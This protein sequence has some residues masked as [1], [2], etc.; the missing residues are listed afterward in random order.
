[1]EYSRGTIS[2]EAIIIRIE[3][4]TVQSLAKSF[5]AEVHWDLASLRGARHFDFPA[6]YLCTRAI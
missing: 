1:M 6:N 4:H 5:E 3:V 2:D